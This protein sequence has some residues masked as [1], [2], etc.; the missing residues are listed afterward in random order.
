MIYF[1]Q[2][3]AD[4]LIKIGYAKN[5]V[6]DRMKTLQCGNPCRLIL[7]MVVDGD[8]QTEADYHTQFKRSRA[9][10]E[11]FRPDKKLMDFIFGAN[12]AEKAEKQ[13]ERSNDQILAE[14]YGLKPTQVLRLRSEMECYD[15]NVDTAERMWNSCH[16]SWGNPTQETLDNLAQRAMNNLTQ[17]VG[18]LGFTVDFTG[19][20]PCVLDTDGKIV[21]I[22]YRRRLRLTPEEL[23][24]E[25]EQRER[26]Q[27]RYR[28]ESEAYHTRRRQEWTAE[29]KRLES[30]WW[31]Q[32]KS[33]DSQELQRLRL[34]RDRGCD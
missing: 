20:E 1:I 11:W 23:E 31:W 2:N 16:P 15:T 8:R 14:R 9:R 30:M 22:H 29:L 19:K 6:E 13:E 21:E 3:T 25:H 5:S 34:W 28:A 24:R 32:G 27:E 12:S 26:A 7:L 10:G 33:G 18:S 17:G 4:M